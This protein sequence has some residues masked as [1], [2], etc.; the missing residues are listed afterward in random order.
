MPLVSEVAASRYLY[1]VD[2]GLSFHSFPVRS[3]KTTWDVDVYNTRARAAGGLADYT[4]EGFEPKVGY[5][6]AIAGCEPYPIRPDSVES[7]A[8]FSYSGWVHPDSASTA[9]A[10]GTGA[11]TNS[12]AIAWNPADSASKVLETSAERLRRTQGMAIG[13]ATTVPFSHATPAAFFSHQSSRDQNWSIA[14]QM[15]L[16]IRPEV[17]IGGGW[18]DS[19]YYDDVDLQLA[20]NSGEW[21]FAHSSDDNGNSNDIILAAALRANLANKRLLGIFRGGERD[22]YEA[23]IPAD[24]P[25]KPS[26]DSTHLD[27]PTLANSSIAA[28]EV[29]SRDPDGFFLVLEQGH[30]DWSNHDSDYVRMVGGVSEL[31]EAVRVISE[32]IDRPGDALDWT[33]T[34][35]IVTA[36]HSNGAMRLYRNFG[37]GELPSASPDLVAYPNGEYAYNSGGQHTSE[38]TAVYVKGFAADKV[39]NYENVYPNCKIMD[40]TDIYRL[41]LDAARP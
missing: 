16:V 31:D 24:A 1:G 36:D 14:A 15:L 37:R 11:K 12:A 22:T 4:P 34:T 5:D 23:P 3:F 25:G 9:T 17:V 41:T 40:D 10:M 29:L 35:V 33:N 18:Q 8:Y 39:H 20:L 7:L 28:L 2:Y 6:P 27:R 13:F 32:Y 19:G 30:I 21:E 26:V 38:L